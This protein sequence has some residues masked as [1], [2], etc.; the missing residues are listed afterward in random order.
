MK[1]RDF[2]TTPNA[3]SEIISGTASEELAVSTEAAKYKLLQQ[4]KALMPGQTI[5]GRIVGRD[6]A[7][8]Q[9][10]LTSDMTL[11]ARLDTEIPVEMGKNMTFQVKN[12]GK[13]LTLS[14]LFANLA[15][16]ENVMKA[17]DMAGIP[18]SDR[19]VAM[20]E[21]MMKEGL[22]IDKQSLQAM[23][24]Q[25]T[26]F[27]K[28]SPETIVQLQKLSVPI[29]AQNLEQAENYKA[30]NHQI[31]KGLTALTGELA[32]VVEAG[33]SQGKIAETNQ[34]LEAVMKAVF[35]EEEGAIQTTVKETESATVP[36]AG[37]SIDMQ[38]GEQTDKVTEE[39]GTVLTG[40]EGPVQEGAK[41]K[42]Q[43]LL[44]QLL[45]LPTE[46]T[47][48]KEAGALHRQLGKEM[49]SLLENEL[50]EQF[51]L[52]PEQVR[53]GKP[54]KELY[55]KIQK[56]L[57]S[58]NEAVSHTV[59]QESSL[60]K[61]V[62]QM[63]NNLDFM[64]QLNQVMNF[65]QLPLKLNEQKAHGDLYVYTNKRSL[66]QKEGSVSAF[67]HLDMEHLGSVDVYVT[68]EEQKVGTRFQVQDDT[69]LNFLYAHMHILD[70]RLQ[71]RGY[72]LSYEMT[73]RNEQ[74][75]TDVLETILDKDRTVSMLSQHG[76]DVRA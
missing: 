40:R 38:A 16:D 48:S 75:T 73:V 8:V 21:S 66:A 30:L 1:L 12:N 36:S 64:N 74:E 32:E 15:T 44:E 57:I 11:T 17:L 72:S 42:V 67:L 4:I 9:I 58:L 41:S 61:G 19:A 27:P 43:N 31:E 29:N 59:G 49:V 10:Q 68:M 2:F 55:E 47:E 65:V 35:R 54:V 52:E 60:A 70:E 20:T 34:L 14:P 23:F 69:M 56:Q 39:K 62:Q 26:A 7:Q 18:A 50:Q 37:E 53:E 51:R 22:S 63:Q 28:A 25:V 3:G 45:H 6:N 71:K 33:Y 5:Q 76:F 24:K 13:S 46:G